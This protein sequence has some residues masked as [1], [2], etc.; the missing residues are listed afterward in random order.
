MRRKIFFLPYKGKPGE[1]PLTIIM[2]DLEKATE[3]EEY[4]EAFYRWLRMATYQ[5]IRDSDVDTRYTDGDI[6]VC[7]RRDGEDLVVEYARLETMKALEQFA[8]G[9]Q[10]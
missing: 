8:H 5:F 2:L 1:D 6:R 7:V 3:G 9:Q 10:R 4:S